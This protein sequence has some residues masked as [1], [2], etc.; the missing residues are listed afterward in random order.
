MQG[1]W[2]GTGE[3]LFFFWR[4][5]ALVPSPPGHH[6]LSLSPCWRRSSQALSSS[7]AHPTTP[8]PRIILFGLNEYPGGGAE[9]EGGREEGRELEP[10]CESSQRPS[11]PSLSP[12]SQL[13]LPPAPLLRTPV[14][15][16]PPVSA[17]ATATLMFT[18]ATAGL[19]RRGPR[20][21][22]GCGCRS[23]REEEGSRIW[24]SF[25]LQVKCFNFDQSYASI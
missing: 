2:A 6:T 13:R 23:G 3:L 15:R 14:A 4:G 22:A 20:R 8:F 17:L 1:M 21:L 12:P 5:Y 11:A 10:G 7:Q 9:K 24:R 25:P 16:H 19:G 18:L